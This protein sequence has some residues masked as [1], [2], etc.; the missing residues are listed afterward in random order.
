M[1]EVHHQLSLGSD[2]MTAAR[3]HG[4]KM[5]WMNSSNK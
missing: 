5:I 1:R 3:T 4:S 2:E